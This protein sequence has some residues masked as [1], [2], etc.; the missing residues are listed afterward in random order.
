MALLQNRLPVPLIEVG[1]RAIPITTV[2]NADS[3]GGIAFPANV[4][5]G[6]KVRITVDVTNAATIQTLTTTLRFGTAN[7]SADGAVLTQ[8]LTAGTAVVGSGQFIYEFIVLSSTLAMATLQF[9][10]GNGAATGISALTTAFKGT[11]SPGFTIV[12]SAATYLGVYF[13]DTVANIITVRATAY[14]VF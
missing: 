14:E 7:T 3:R 11:P 2:T 10:N 13:S 1:A 9:F 5:V 6:M 4:R 12:T 8:A